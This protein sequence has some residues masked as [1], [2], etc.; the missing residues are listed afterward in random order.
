MTEV[1]RVREEETPGPIRRYPV[2]GWAER[3]GVVAGIS[4][5]SGTDD[6]SADF[7]LHSDQPVGPIMARWRAFRDSLPEFPG[8]V[9][10][11]QVHG[12]EVR[13]QEGG[14]DGWLQVDDVDG[15]ATATRGVLLTLT[16]A[17]CIPVYLVAPRQGAVALLHAGWRGAAAGILT[18]GL[19]VLA[20]QAGAS[21][22]DVIMHCGIGICGNCFEVGSDVLEA[23]GLRGDHP[24]KW[25]VDV[26]G[27]LLEEAGKRGVAEATT[28]EWCTMHDFDRFHSHR[29]SEAGPG[30]MVAYLGLP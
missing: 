19:E 18:R 22:A 5:R 30:R 25:A 17:D 8:L 9:Q 26:R 24:G 2:P 6:L 1:T 3:F 10:G 21:P 14:L 28:S 13:W 12:T 7:G 11:Y 15:H 16:V 27:E 4:G 23:F 29:A 20:Q